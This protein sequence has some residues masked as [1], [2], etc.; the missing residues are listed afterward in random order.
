MVNGDMDPTEE[1]KEKCMAWG[2][3][4]LCGARTFILAIVIILAFVAVGIYTMDVEKLY[5][6]ALLVLGFFFG[7]KMPQQATTTK[8]GA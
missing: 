6:A 3:G 4:Y 5:N 8:G 2:P 1:T 7:S